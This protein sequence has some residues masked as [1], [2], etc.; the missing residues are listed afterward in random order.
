MAPADLVSGR[1]ETEGQAHHADADVAGDE[2]GGDRA[3]RVVDQAERDGEDEEHLQAGADVYQHDEG[4]PTKQVD[5][6]EQQRSVHAV[7]QP[8]DQDHAHQVDGREQAV[9]GRRGDRAE[10]AKRGVGQEV[11]LDHAGGRIA[12]E[13][14]AP[15]QDLEGRHLEDRPA[16]LCEARLAL[17]P[18]L[19]RRALPEAAREPADHAEHHDDGRDTERHEGPAPAVGR[20]QQRQERDDQELAGGRA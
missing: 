1:D 9:G 17:S 11:R 20:Q 6:A 8:A 7:R 18:V 10:A 19:G 2:A 14:E 4:Q 16:V 12:A 13:E 15:E 5:R 3:R